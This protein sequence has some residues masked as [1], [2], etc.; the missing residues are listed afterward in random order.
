MQGVIRYNGWYIS[1]SD[2][3]TRK[4]ANK[5]RVVG[6]GYSTGETAKR[7]LVKTKGQDKGVIL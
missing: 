5:V 2:A 1:S 6:G 7:G 4:L 3:T